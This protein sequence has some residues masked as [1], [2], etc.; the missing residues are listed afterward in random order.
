MAERDCSGCSLVGECDQRR[1]IRNYAVGVD[2]SEEDEELGRRGKR[3]FKDSGQRMEL[4]PMEKLELRGEK[5][6]VV[7][8]TAK[9]ML[10]YGSRRGIREARQRLA[11]QNRGG[12]YVQDR[13]GR[14][15]RD[16]RYET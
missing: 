2:D 13:M 9:Y 4:C 10:E 15:R 16:R 3:R 12:V 7:S 14:I 5:V 8:D 11:D 1:D 6:L